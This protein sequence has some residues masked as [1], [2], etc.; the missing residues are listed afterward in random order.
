[1]N[2]K[3][4]V[5][6]I[7]AIGLLAAACAPAPTEEP[8]AVPADP[9]WERIQTTGKMLVG[10]S[11][12]Y[13]PFAFYNENFVL[14]GFDVALIKEV[15]RRI[16]VP[17]EVKDFAFDGLGTAL[18]IGQI[19]AAIAAISVTEERQGV[20]DFSNV[21]YIGAAAALARQGSGIGPLTGLDQLVQYRVGVQ[22]GS[23]YQTE[24][25][26]LVELGQMPPTNLFAY[27]RADEGTTALSQG[28]ID[29]FVMDE[30]PAEKA[31]LAGGLE[32]VGT[33]INQQRYAIALPKGSPTLTGMVNQALV[34]MNNDGTLARLMQEHLKIAPEDVVVLPTPTP[35]P[36]QTP[37]PA[38]S[39]ATPAPGACVDGM[40]YVADL[41]YDDENMKDPPELDKGE[42]F[43]KGWRIR[44]VGTCTWTNS[45]SLRFVFG[46]VPEAQMSG[47]TTNVAGE[48]RPNQN[49]DMYVDLKAPNTSG[50]F[51]GFW[52]M[53]NAN[54]Q[55][56]GETVWVGIRVPGEAKPEPTKTPK[57]EP[58]AV[59][60]QPP[61]ISS[62]DADPQQ[63][64]VGSCVTL[65]WSFSG[66]SLADAW[67]TRNTE[68]IFSDL[69]LNGS[70][71][72]CGLSEV[73]EYTYVLQVSSEFAGSA[74]K[75][76]LVEVIGAQPK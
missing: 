17:V 34:D 21:Y 23:V 60:E 73:G 43:T 31:A 44:N 53:F 16:G 19:D 47:R 68:R 11:G 27:I 2:W 39:T 13:P 76:V 35:L 69:P 46:N 1:M 25:Q 22:A 14:D 67:I 33:G 5:V 75:Q 6:A 4:M 3:M 63:V 66:E 61:A 15:G 56:F 59:P 48:V 32:I 40:A 65:S 64:P 9:A 55:A 74:Q 72:D 49:Y 20:V 58:T 41:N 52:Q 10:T 36:Q 26:N 51:Q 24:L 54:G 70:D 62:F 29:L 8:P 45:Y 38:P 18:Q 42:S 57:P 7:M 12:D 50:T 30:L 28:A 71:Q 37:T